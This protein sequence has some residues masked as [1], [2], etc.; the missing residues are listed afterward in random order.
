MPGGKQ[1][2]ANRTKGNVR[3]S[4]S[5]RAAEMLAS[6]G[7]TITVF[8]GFDTMSGLGYVPAGFATEEAD[9][10]VDADFRMVLRK[11]SKRDVTT[12]IKTTQ[13]F[14]TLCREKSNDEVSGVLPYW[15]R[16]YN[17][18]CIDN[19]RRV[20]EATQHAFEQLVL[21]VRRNLAPHLKGLM[22]AWLLSQCD[23]F[24]P[25]A[26]AAKAAFEAAFP[27]VKQTGAIMFC[28]NEIL[29]YL[30]DNLLQQ[31]PQTL[32]D[33]K[34][35]PKEDIE[36][37]YVKV[38][39]SSLMA[40]RLFLT[41]IPDDQ[42][43]DLTGLVDEILAAPKLWKHSKNP[44][45][46][47]RSAFY[48]MLSS[49]C[50]V[51]PS[52]ATRYADKICPLVMHHVDESDPLI[53]PPLWEAVLFTITKIEDCWK[54]INPRKA[55][56]PKLW[57]LMK[58]G[59]HGSANVVC[60]SLLPLLSKIPEEVI[61]TGIAFYNEF[62]G[63]M[64]SSLCVEH[65]IQSPSDC[66]AVVRAYLECL[67]YCL[68]KTLETEDNKKLQDFFILD[69]L[70][71]LI[72]SSL[73][74]TKSPLPMSPIYTQLSD[75]LVFLHK[76][77][78]TADSTI[79]RDQT[80]KILKT[81][82]DRFSMICV[83]CVDQS[84][85]AAS[86]SY[87]LDRMAHMFQD[88]RNPTKPQ[89]KKTGRVMFAAPPK[90][91]QDK[92]EPTSV[93]ESLDLDLKEMD[94]SKGHDLDESLDD[95]K[96]LLQDDG[97]CLLLLGR[98]CKQTFQIAR[99]TKSHPHIQFCSRVL[100]AYKVK[101]IFSEI[102]SDYGEGVTDDVC[103]TLTFIRDVVVPWMKEFEEEHCTEEENALPGLVEL[104]FAVY[105]VADAETKV[106][107]LSYVCQDV[108]SANVMYHFMTKLLSLQTDRIIQKWLKGDE[109]G[110]KLVAFTKTLCEDSLQS[111]DEEADDLS[112]SWSLLS[113][114]LTTQDNFEPVIASQYVN[115]ILRELQEALPSAE[116]GSTLSQPELEKIVSFICELAHN[117]FSNFKSCLMM[118]PTEDL[119]F[120]LFQLSLQE[121]LPLTDSQLE[122]IQYTWQT[123]VVALVQ[124]KGGYFNPEGFFYR[125]ASLLKFLV[126][127]G[128]TSVTRLDGLVGTTMKLLTTVADG[129]DTDVGFHD[130]TIQTLIGQ[131]K[132][133][134]STAL[135]TGAWQES[136]LMTN[137]LLFTSLP[138]DG[139]L[140]SFHTIPPSVT[141]VFFY[142]ELLSQVAKQQADVQSGADLCGFELFD[143]DCAMDL[144]YMLVYCKA[145]LGCKAEPLKTTEVGQTYQ[146]L[147][148]LSNQL[149]SL[150]NSAEKERLLKSAAERSREEGGLSSLCLE[151]IL[152]HQ[153]S[154]DAQCLVGSVDK[155]LSLP[156]VHTLACILHVQQVSES[157]IQIFA[158]V[159]AAKIITCPSESVTDISGGL[160]S[161]NGLNQ[162]LKKASPLDI[163][164]RQTVSPEVI[165]EVINKINQ[166]KEEFDELF[167]FSSDVHDLEWCH[168]VLNIEVMSLMRLAVEWI[169]TKLD[170]KCW[171]FIL[172]SLVSWIQSC[173]MSIDELPKNLS[174]QA[175]A[176][177]VFQLL[178][179]VGVCINTVIQEDEAMPGNLLSEW[180]EFFSE[181]IYSTLFPL[182]INFIG[183]IN[184]SDLSLGQEYLLG[185]LGQALSSM[186]QDLL[187]NHS[188]PAKLVADDV[189]NL[190]DQDQTLINHLCP[191]LLSPCRIVQLTAYKLLMKVMDKL[192]ESD[193]GHPLEGE[194][195][196]NETARPPPQAL[197][198]I[199]QTSSD[200]VKIILE[201]VK[202]GECMEIEPYIAEYALSTAY[203][204][205]WKLLLKFFK[206]A[207][208][209]LRV[210]YA[211][212]LKT[213]GAIHSLL[214]DVFCLMPESPVIQL[215][216][217]LTS[218][219]PMSKL[220]AT[221]NLFA[222]EPILPIRGISSSREVKHVACFV[223]HT[224]LQEL[225]AL[226]RQWVNDRD[227]KTASVVDSFTTKFVSPV[228]ISQEM[229]S[230][231]TKERKF[232]NMTVKARPAARD[233]IATYC[234]EEA[235]MELMVQLPAN[236]PLGTIT[237]VVGK[238]VG[239]ADT[240]WRNWMLQMTTFLNHQ[241][242]S[243]I[244]GLKLWKKNVDKRFE[245][246]E[247]CMICF[248][249]I[250]GSNYQLPKLLCRTCKKKFH[251]DC[252]YKW[253]NTSNNSTCPLCRN[254][255]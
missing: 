121:G 7:G 246:V 184:L 216:D 74:E 243:I 77:N 99:L 128:C 244:E 233:I 191:L 14:G 102:L 131:L 115:E 101:R 42:R 43:D 5:G 237:V 6:S 223:Y 13:E 190:S 31:T 3:P 35:T 210:Q 34:N 103:V 30:K 85:D 8:Q 80:G 129:L 91:K 94:L 150:L 149:F 112:S 114:A 179:A 105:E 54:H 253:F 163:D 250:H 36:S 21:R 234:V 203:L 160:G 213:T 178:E 106:H 255:F 164:G 134:G 135:V 40:M 230:L 165:L 251:S 49:V 152:T 180:S 232:N 240:Q 183:A 201:D 139:A 12:K 93:S 242:G 58:A 198:R 196:Q 56:F 239:V 154:E 25:A 50:Q 87:I 140:S 249:V 86:P 185:H 65:I 67:R 110:G 207:K 95:M 158:E 169:P 16:L 111:Q 238:R 61:G 88:I 159:L 137:K 123:G 32:S 157:D 20:R 118:M 59:F 144:S 109:F 76:M 195:Q 136:T 145:L 57:S 52:L 199:L 116:K 92:S 29:Q 81:F 229:A 23:T 15:P 155:V 27:P 2:Q 90:R 175:F 220:T 37:K 63:N 254:L 224:A 120:T 10:S 177:G 41:T 126:L 247:D 211:T 228:L 113:L 71:P 168:I 143:A 69:Q 212:Y 104:L 245:G 171:D 64:K 194:D 17:K 73:F 215:K 167:C 51:Y 217:I 97:A 70:I 100:S 75:L 133:D 19:D 193:I 187:R 89:K 202:C 117:F 33:P 147:V 197:V 146:R 1:K 221:K 98:L 214:L 125:A 227:K 48:S 68:M 107:I 9:S 72:E 182:F 222:E 218:Q 252:L 24:P 153:L 119:L 44:S 78:V 236:H 208:S 200:A 148:P 28:K 66:S 130:S 84:Q 209:E 47:I 62:F 46:M 83:Q 205:C 60:P 18:L 219:S 173:S 138:T 132:I 192:P 204:L 142:C 38:V 122:K 235:T 162:V 127:N 22:G 188:L 82:W 225:P 79:K 206:G 55:L 108:T 241:N 124:Q 39:S 226:V 96:Y 166:W 174:V 156:L 53:C 186:P 189:S 170:N 231:Q 181:G 45:S 176:S 151:N 26:L 141:P 4:S 161:L 11:F 172:C 248:S